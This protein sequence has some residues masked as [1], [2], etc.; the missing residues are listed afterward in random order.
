[1]PVDLS[2]TEYGTGSPVVI[3]HGLFGSKRNW[4]SIAKQLG[5]THRIIAVDQR[6]H[7]E[8]PWTEDH[9]YPHMA[10]DLAHLIRRHADGRATV[11]GHSMGGKAAMALALSEPDLVERLVVVDIAPA[12]SGGT[13]IDFVHTMAE[14][15]LSNLSRRSEVEAALARS[16][17]EPAIRAFL[18]QNVT[19]G[20]DGLQWQLNLKALAENF[21]A[22]LEFP[23]YDDL[24]AYT[25]QT[26]FI[27]GG[28][29]DYIQPHHQAEIE[30]LF[31]GAAIDVIA[32]AG[33]WVHAEQPKAFIETIHRLLP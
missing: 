32:D 28:R 5:R 22:I 16:I 8:S 6:N 21:D 4:S 29:S 23:D 1:M 25:G 19:A 9:T 26:H 24:S 17:P 20:E 31:P 10:E 12:P 3:V 2:F 30:R 7:G 13:L 27:A 18:A 33:H 11:I 15:D 14:M